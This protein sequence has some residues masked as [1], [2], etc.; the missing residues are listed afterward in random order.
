MQP[1]H[2]DRL[3]FRDLRGQQQRAKAPANG[4]GRQQA[5]RQRIGIGLCHRTKDVAFDA[6]QRE[7][8][9]EPAMMIVAE[10]KMAC[11]TSLDAR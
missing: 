1:T 5:T 10:K 2:Q 11:V 6:A 9:Q 8:R 7:Q 3:G 4:E